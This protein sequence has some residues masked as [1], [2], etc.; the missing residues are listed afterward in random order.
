[1]KTLLSSLIAMIALM[2]TVSQAQAV[3]LKKYDHLDPKHLIKDAPLKQALTYFEM[4]QSKFPNKN[5]IVVVDFTLNAR[6]DRL[7]IINMKTGAV[8]PHMTTVG[9]GSDKNGDGKADSFSNAPKSNKTS[10][11]F[12]RTAETYKGKHG[13]SL[14]LDGLSSTNSNAR[15]RGIVMH[16][17]A[18]VDEE[19]DRAGRSQGCFVLDKDDLAGVI[20][21]IKGGA[22]IYAWAGG[23]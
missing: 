17:A 11:G 13:N 14:K 15:A 4:N 1:M 22:M 12:Y 7:F 5:F 20:K 16:T 3:D 6:Q 18:Y 21:R 2:G 8:E 19:S 9:K 10:L 23:K